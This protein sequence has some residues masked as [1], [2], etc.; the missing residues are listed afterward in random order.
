MKKLTRAWAEAGVLLS[1]A[2]VIAGAWA[3]ASCPAAAPMWLG[4]AVIGF[5]VSFTVCCAAWQKRRCQSPILN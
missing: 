5:V 1:L 4:L 3:I 2:A